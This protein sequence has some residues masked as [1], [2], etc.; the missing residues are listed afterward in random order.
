M[1][2]DIHNYFYLRYFVLF[3]TDDKTNKSVSHETLLYFVTV[4]NN[5]IVT[6]VKKQYYGS[7]LTYNTCKFD[8]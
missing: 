3:K 4:T 2:Y 5:I 8:M 7:F 6:Y 1:I